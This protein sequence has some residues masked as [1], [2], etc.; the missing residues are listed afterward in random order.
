MLKSEKLPW[1]LLIVYLAALGL[2]F[3]SVQAILPTF[4]QIPLAA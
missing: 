3:P 4:P 2:S 1:G